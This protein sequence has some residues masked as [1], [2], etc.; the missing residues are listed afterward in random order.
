MVAL[1]RARKTLMLRTPTMV[2]HRPQTPSR[3][4][5]GRIHCIPRLP[6]RT[7][8]SARPLSLSAIGLLPPSTL[9]NPLTPRRCLRLA[10]IRNS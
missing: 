9:H 8:A 2:D 10:M 6:L 4:S 7:T 3:A 5:S 1:L